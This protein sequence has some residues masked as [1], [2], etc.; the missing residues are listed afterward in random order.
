MPDPHENLRWELSGPPRPIKVLIFDEQSVVRAGL[1]AMLATSPGLEVVG[2]VGD[3][4]SAVRF[5]SRFQPDVVLM[6]VRLAS[7]DGISAVQQIV[8][9]DGRPPRVLVLTNVAMSECV[10]D[11]LRAGASGFILKHSSV[12]RIIDA[13]HAVHRGD[14]PLDPAITRS[15]VGVYPR[16]SSETENGAAH[17]SLSDREGQIVV[18]LAHGSNTAEVACRLNL[19]VATVKTHI[20]H[21]LT[22][23]DVRDRVQLVARAYETGFVHQFA[24]SGDIVRL[25]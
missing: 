7:G 16:L 17:P 9:R 13:L 15:V 6:E 20:S 8:G 1:R 24:S 3:V 11:C 21:I 12:E 19:S 4:K 10:F 2:D 22:K 5:S 14:C 18:L 25:D 23:W